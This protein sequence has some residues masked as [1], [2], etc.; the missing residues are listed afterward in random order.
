LSFFNDT[1]LKNVDR[2]FI[3]NL[4]SFFQ[5]MILVP[6]LAPLLK[7]LL[8]FP[9]NSV[10]KFI[11]KGVYSYVCIRSENRTVFSFLKLALANRKFFK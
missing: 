5:L 11:F 10:F 2:T 8:K 4:H 6:F 1:L 9:H 3:L 7:Y